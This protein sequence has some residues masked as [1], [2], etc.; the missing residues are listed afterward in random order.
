MVF[1]E[2]S[3]INV[4]VLYSSMLFKDMDEEAGGLP[5]TPRTATYI[6]GM[7]DLLG[8]IISMYV[9]KIFSRKALLV[10]GNFTISILHIII[11]FG[12]LYGNLNLSL[13]G[14]LVFVMV[15]V[16]TGGPVAW[17]YAAETV[18]DTGLG[19]CLLFLWITLFLLSFISP[20]LMEPDS[21]VG[22]H[23]L[24]F[25]FSTINMLATVYAY[26]FIKET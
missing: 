4:I 18:T 23:N 21:F 7:V 9:V 2:L 25:I 10:G 5:I 20:I 8:G 15:F 1:R 12:C 14:I 22:P 13:I 6:A 19:I 3:G 17:I 16:N 26:V 24:F 11:G